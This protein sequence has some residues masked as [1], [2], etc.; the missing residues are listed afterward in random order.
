MIRGITGKWLLSVL[1]TM[2][3]GLLLLGT[4]SY[5]VVTG[6][7]ASFVGKNLEDRTRIYASLL[8]EDFSPK[9]LEYIRRMEQGSGRWVFVF[10]P[11]GELYND[12]PKEKAL[13]QAVQD[14]LRQR[15]GVQRHRMTVPGS[16]RSALMVA[17]PFTPSEKARGTVAVVL[18]MTWL[19]SIFHSL[20]SLMLLAG[21]GALLIGGGIALLLSHQTVRPILDI[22][23]AAVRLAHGDY[24]TRVS[25]RGN[26]ELTS[27]GKSMNELAQSLDS[28][29][30]SRRTFLSEVS[31]ELRT[32]LS[33][34]KGYT[35]L[36]DER[37]LS[38]EKSKRLTQVIR[39]QT[40]RLER[41]VEDLV[42]LS[43]LDE[44]KLEVDK[45]YILPAE[46]VEK[47]IQELEPHAEKNGV[48][49]RWSSQVDQTLWFD[50]VRFDQILFNLLDN[51]IRHSEAGG[52]VH[53][54]LSTLPE[55]DR[56]RMEVQD[57]GMGMDTEELERIW[58]RFY[59]VEKSRSREHGGSGLGLSIVRRLVHLHQGTIEVR[60]RPG[61]GTVF[62]MEFPM[63]T[64]GGERG[65]DSIE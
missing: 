57:H 21:V 7:F 61:E 19:S 23:N 10:Q 47:V 12:K 13:I 6:H 55:T 32:P 58:D 54:S 53:V 46:R 16:R 17:S 1:V 43:R 51:A 59:R 64:S 41:L 63:W 29:R 60:S 45:A 49:L 9:T 5:Q 18:E 8:S 26:D 36:L 24:Q 2:T 30:S 42:T 48:Q 27:L 56:M 3:I 15:D 4:A 44:G 34:L 40:D 33:Y 20:E 39:E 37:D 35:A 11:S 38:K 50:P 31:H 65:G 25:V 14:R 28:Y 52:Q 62:L 22:R